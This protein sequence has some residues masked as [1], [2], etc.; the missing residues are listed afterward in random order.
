MKKRVKK[1]LKGDEL[2]VEKYASQKVRDA[3]WQFVVDHARRNKNGLYVSFGTSSKQDFWLRVEGRILGYKRVYVDE[4]EK[5]LKEVH[6]YHK[7]LTKEPKRIAKINYNIWKKGSK[8]QKIAL[9]IYKKL[10]KFLYENN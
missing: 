8:K 7:K 3:V 4:L 9:W 1:Y 2:L 6:H 10:H 5:H